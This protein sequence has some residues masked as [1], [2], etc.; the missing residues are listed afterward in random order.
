MPPKAGGGVQRF[1]GVS[2]STAGSQ[3]RL[4]TGGKADDFPSLES[5]DSKDVD[6]FKFDNDDGDSEP[7]RPD[8]SASDV[9][10]V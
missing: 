1:G 7:G 5:I 2:A 6:S 10:L 3:S 4:S 8:K 9:R